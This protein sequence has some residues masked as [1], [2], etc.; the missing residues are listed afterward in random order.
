M[1]TSAP[2][3]RDTLA[4][5]ELFSGPSREAL[6]EAMVPARSR[7]LA[8]DTRIFDQGD[9]AE[10]AHALVDGSVRIAQSG[11]DGEQV[12]IRLI[13]LGEMFGTAALFVDRQ[14]PA[15]AIAIT[16]SLEISWREAELRSLIERHPTIATN[17]I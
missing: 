3:S 7:D 15:D 13:G 10:R 17:I 5:I 14:Y 11:P 2:L 12:L 1:T 6:D 8:K 4:A 16:D 9:C